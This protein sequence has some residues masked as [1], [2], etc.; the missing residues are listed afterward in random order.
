MST[1]AH[2]H[3]ALELLEELLSVPSPSGREERMAAL[4]RSKLD[5]LGYAHETDGAGNVLVRLDGRD[6]NAPLMMLAAHIDEIAM[7]VTS[8]EEDGRLRVAASGGLHPWKLGECPVDIVGDG[9]ILRG[10]FSFGST[11]TPEASAKKVDWKAA[12]VLTGRSKADLMEAGVR[13]GSTAVPVREVRGPILFGDPADPLV[14]AWTFDD[15]ASVV[16]QLRM[17]EAL[18][19]QTIPPQCSTIVAFTVHEEG[20]CHGAKVLANRERP[21]IFIAVDGCPMPPGTPLK[22]DGRP[23]TWSKDQVTHFD[24]RLVR[25]LMRAAHEA[26]TELQTVVYEGA[27]SDASMVY[28]SGAAPRVATVGIVRENS[29]GYEVARLSVF[30]NLVNTLIRFVESGDQGV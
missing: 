8:M 30:D 18:R 11:H 9:D 10:V 26:G 22:L 24:Q 15:R 21:E 5:A 7:V 6:P 25:G 2:R 3:P 4:V 29:H 14:A 16:A 20:G 23:G 12:Y 28:A 27:A 19:E 1:C 13:P 17:L